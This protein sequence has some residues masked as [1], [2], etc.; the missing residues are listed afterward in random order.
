MVLTRTEIAG[1]IPQAGAMSLLDRVLAFDADSLCAAAV[2]QRAADHPLRHGGRLSPLAG[3]E[4]AAQAMALHGALTAG[5][6]RRAGYL[7]LIKDTHWAVSRLD[8][9]EDELTIE[10]RL[11]VR[12]QDSVMYR[13]CLCAAGASL[14]EGRA[15]VFFEA[16][17]ER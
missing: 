7:A 3:I 16:R 13:F 14:I 17:E 6:D 9:I 15:A 8:D 10:V 2:G 11:I 4:Y 12:Q 1:L 5:D